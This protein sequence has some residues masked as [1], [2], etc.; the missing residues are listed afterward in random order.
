MP[1]LSNGGTFFVTFTVTAWVDVFTRP[2]Y[3]HIMVDSIR[4][5][6]EHKGLSLFAWCLMSNH[7]HMIASAEGP[8][9][10]DEVIRDMKKF[11]SKKISKAISEVP[12]SRSE[13][14]SNL[15]RFRGRNHPKK[16]N[17]KF[18]KDNYDCFELFTD[19]VFEQKLNYI[20]E[21]PVRAE[22]VEEPHH[23]LYSSARNYA[24]MPGLLDVIIA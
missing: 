16:I 22:I 12:E 14:M 9:S 23:Y 20:H 3:R 17:S 10:L 1:N 2:V 8:Q 19:H 11:T 24:G 21:N 6:Q 5:C 7:I 4:Y 13:W 18:W 15:F